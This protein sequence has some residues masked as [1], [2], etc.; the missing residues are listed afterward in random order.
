M[1]LGPAS[2]YLAILNGWDVENY[3]TDGVR[4][5]T[6]Y[7][8]TNQSL[9]DDV[10]VKYTDNTRRMVNGTYL[11]TDIN[12]VRNWLED[13]KENETTDLQVQLLSVQADIASIERKYSFINIEMP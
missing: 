10:L 7:I 9:T 8:K 6:M 13:Q 4:Y 1:S 2:E 12:D 11:F 5:V 3:L